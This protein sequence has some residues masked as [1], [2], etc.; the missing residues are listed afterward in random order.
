MLGAQGLDKARELLG[1]ARRRVLA[2]EGTE[3]L[4]LLVCVGRVPLN[5]AGLA[6]EPVGN[7]HLVLCVFV[8]LGQDVSALDGLVEVAE[9]VV[10]DDDALRRLIGAGDIGLQAIV[11]AVSAPGVV[12]GGYDRRDVAAGSLVL[13]VTDSMSKVGALLTRPHCGRQ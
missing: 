2:E 12:A 9:D 1:N 10:D 7:E 3:V 11:L 4:L 13:V 6:L 8:A 5:G